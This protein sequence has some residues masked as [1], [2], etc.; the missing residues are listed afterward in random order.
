M[1]SYLRVPP[2]DQEDAPSTGADAC[3][4]HPVCNP[5]RSLAPVRVEII[6][7]AGEGRAFGWPSHD[8]KRS[9]ISGVSWPPR[10]D[11]GWLCC[12]R[13][14]RPDPH[15]IRHRDRDDRRAHTS[16]ERDHGTVGRH[17]PPGTPRSHPDLEPHPPDPRAARIRNP[18]QHPPATP[19]S[20]AG[21][22]STPEP[23]TDH[24]YRTDHRH[25]LFALFKH[26]LHDNQDNS[27]RTWHVDPE[28][29]LRYQGSSRERM[30]PHAASCTTQQPVFAAP[31]PER[32]ASVATER[33]ARGRE[34]SFPR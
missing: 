28:S 9:A 10:D 24:Q 1:F 2:L 30:Q 13:P 12:P 14:V 29:M 34:R 7:R 15:P 20:G 27:A 16:N 31:S 22:S 26:P 5:V 25:Y 33:T 23:G 19:H 11:D 32:V 4:P 18:L 21:S 8:D 3:L 17:L 6:I